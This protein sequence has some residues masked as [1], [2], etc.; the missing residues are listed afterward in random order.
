MFSPAG[1]RRILEE[2]QARKVDHTYLI[3]ALLTL[4]IWHQTFLDKPGEE[5]VL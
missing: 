4:E 3:Y 2:N 1:V 5:V